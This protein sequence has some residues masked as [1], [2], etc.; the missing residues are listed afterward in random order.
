MYPGYVLQVDPK[1][2]SWTCT[3][4]VRKKGGNDTSRFLV[5][6]VKIE[7]PFTKR[8]RIARGGDKN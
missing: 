2:G 4:G 7:L 8:W 5:Q 6:G 1:I 3:W